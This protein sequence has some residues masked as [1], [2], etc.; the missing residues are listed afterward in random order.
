MDSRIGQIV[1]NL[2]ET[3]ISNGGGRSWTV[4][5]DTRDRRPKFHG[6]PVCAALARH[7]I[8]HVGVAHEPAPFEIVRTKLGGSYFLATFEGEGR[9]SVDGR[10]KPCRSGEAFLL[11]PGTLQR[12]RAPPQGRWGFCWVRYQERPGQEPLAAAY[13]PIL[14]RFD[15]E[16]L[17]HAI[18]G[19]HRACRTATVPAAADLWVELIQR[20][21]TSFVRL[22]A[23]DSR[24]WRLW[25][26]VSA[27][28]GR[29]WTSPEMARVAYVSEKHLERLSK[30]EL[31][32]TPRQQLIWLRMRRAAELLGDERLTI[33]NVAAQVGYENPFVFSST[34]KRFMGW[35]P[36]KY[37]GR[38]S[39]DAD[40]RR[41]VPR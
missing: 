32:C 8:V 24:L 31:G 39:I 22:S 25:E 19:F 16:A 2:S 15:S 10:W 29:R 18:L 26:T 20:Y 14:A 36:S 37:P 23:T 28:L 6:A 17:R 7:Q 41:P 38:R 3:D 4:R 9:V 12:F 5:A 1:Q 11:P 33:E 13:S 30:R 40:G 34:F 21:V 35:P 27:D